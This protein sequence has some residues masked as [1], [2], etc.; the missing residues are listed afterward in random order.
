MASTD[1]EGILV[2]A[3]RGAKKA[4]LSIGQLESIIGALGSID[5]PAIEP[6]DAIGP[7]E[8]I[9]GPLGSTI[10]RLEFIIGPPDSRET[11]QA[12]V[13]EVPGSHDML[14]AANSHRVTIDTASVSVEDNLSRGSLLDH[15]KARFQ[16]CNILNQRYPLI[17][18]TRPN[19]PQIA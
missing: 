2:W 15:G 18:Q 17:K 10:G 6:L 1:A 19:Q 7:L 11:D 4:R 14:V 16:V 5:P 13:L 3:L 9:I 12:I 8:F